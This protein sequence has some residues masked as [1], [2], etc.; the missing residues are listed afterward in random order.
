MKRWLLFAT[1]LLIAG[2]ALWVW[3]TRQ[4]LADFPDILPAY[5]AKE[6]CSCRFV[7]G[8]DTAYCRGYV[9]QYLPL[10]SLEE[11]TARQLV[12]ARGLGR[13]QQAA[14]QGPGEGCRLLP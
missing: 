12:S 4:A 11:D 5:S 6:Y 2:A 7:M 10:D 14:V 13:R 8:F 3:N 9:E 1:L